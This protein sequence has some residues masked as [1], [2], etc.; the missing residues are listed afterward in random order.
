[1][2]FL[3]GGPPQTETFD[4]KM[5]AGERV[6]NI[7]GQVQT[8]LP[9]AMFGGTFPRQHGTHIA[10]LS[11]APSARAAVDP[12]GGLMKT[13]GDFSVLGLRGFVK[14]VAL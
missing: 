11:C 13:I 7:T 1:M 10:P 6:R 9:G 8:S 3:K 2:L 4:P 14:F 12:T 5:N